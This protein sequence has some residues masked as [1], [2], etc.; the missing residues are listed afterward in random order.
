MFPVGRLHLRHLILWAVPLVGLACGGD[1]ITDVVLP[2]LTITTATNGAEI[3]SDGYSISI[4][5][6]AAQAIGPNTSLTINQIAAGQHTVELSGIA[7]NCVVGGSNPQTVSVVSGETVTS[8]FEI[9]CS[10]EGALQIVI[11]TSAAGGEMDPDGYALSLD[12]QAAQPIGANAT[13]TLEGIAPGPHTVA[14][15]GIAVNCGVAGQNPQSVSVLSGSTT[16]LSF[17]ITCSPGT[18]S[19]QVVTT[20][21]G[22]GTDPD[23]F[24]LL[25]DGTDRGAIGVSA[26]SSLTE[27]TAGPHSIGLT[28]LAGNCQISG[29]NPRAVSVTAGGT[30]QVS[31]AVSCAAP[32]PTTGDLKIVTVTTGP[33]Q[34]ANGYLISV[35]GGPGQPIGTSATVT[36]SNVTA[37]LHTIELQGLAPNC[38]VT[39]DN[40][41]GAA[42]GA[43][44]TARV[45]FAVT[46]VAT[47]GSLRITVTGLPAGAASA[48]TVSG[49][50]SFSQ[51]V[52]ATRTLSG[53][54]P[55][56]YTISASNV[57]SSGTTYTAS[58]S[59]PTVAVAA[60]ASP[61]VTVSYT[62]P[63]PPTL[64]LRIQDLYLT[65][66]TQTLTSSVPL[67]SGR[68]GFLRVFVVANETNTAK[69]IVRV[70]FRNGSSPV[71]ERTINA[72]GGS[73][74]TAVQEG[75][76]GSSWNLPVEAALIRSGLSIEAT[77]DPTGAIA[78][79]NESDNGNTKAATVRTVPTARIRFVPVT[80]GSNPPGDVSNP[81]QLMALARRMHPLN[82][83]EIDVHSTGFTASA[84]LLPGG[85][86]GDGWAQLVSDLDGLRV[87]EGSNQTY[88][89]V[90]NLSYG[91]NAGLV[92]LAFQGVPT[93]VGWD[94]PGD[95]PRVVAHELGHTWNRRHSPCGSPPAG[96]IDEV[97]PS[98]GAYSGGKIGV[99]GYDV[100][101]GSLKAR[102]VPDIM[103][104]CV[105]P[106][107][108]LSD[109]TYRAVMDFRHANSGSAIAAAVAQP[110]LLIWGRIVNGRPLLEPA[111]EIITRPSLPSRPGPYSVAATGVDGSRLFALSFDV[112]AIQDQPASSGHFAFA[113][114]LDQAR[115]GRIGS[116]RLEGPTGS[117]A[118]SAPLAQLRAGPISQS[119]VA[120]RE[121]QNVSLKWNAAT[122][123]MIM[124]RDPDTGEILSFA[125]GGS[126]TIRTAKGV[127]DLDVSDGVRSQRVRV[128]INRS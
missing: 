114:P 123:P 39:G 5:G 43:G 117:A 86:T 80:Q 111:F 92:G 109:Y 93:A 64:N 70:R 44:E 97:Y 52:T 16:S 1:A 60:G 29:P 15:S 89:G 27:I 122:H 38:G 26:T 99:F 112:A 73:T 14:L 32:A 37:V 98:T 10:S 67:V 55:G 83:V 71:I 18:G 107:P 4:D 81:A 127:L 56:A 75:T 49:P 47:V 88:F 9:T 125:R 90:V 120:R 51:A 13:L 24:A 33:S 7:G 45:T 119:I 40:P 25:L 78:E 31:F 23:G 124:V 8:A 94:D 62:G 20:T 115:A 108:W 59:N 72:P 96:T 118:S 53:L 121:G 100:T 6:Q 106:S 110:S 69:P 17:E 36:L 35:D 22:E 28:G 58:V 12:G 30:A 126:A 19:V 21:T 95:A 104:Y 103:G 65:Q 74:P 102:S 79:S 128:A 63:T 57:V 105:E 113:V 2:L 50:G 76:L 34:D 87:A 84:P 68:A 77:V 66:S 42:V 82:A 101:A 85:G 48:I 91:L 116:L 54:A 3:D 41:L 61:T 11:T 46:C